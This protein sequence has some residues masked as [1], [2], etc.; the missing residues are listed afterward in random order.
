MPSDPIDPAVRRFAVRCLAGG[1]LLML[2]GVVLGAFGTH[3]LQEILTPKR[4]ASFQT[5]VTYQFLHALGLILI[6]VVARVTQPS[7]WLKRAA[8]LMLLGVV[9]FA[10][11]IYAMTFGAPR[12]LGMVAPVGGVSFM[13][14]WA[15]LALHAR[16]QTSQGSGGRG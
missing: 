6:G 8:V 4:L 5:G 15:A 12:W 16:Q 7:P 1:A 11:S 10:G 3:V 14:G 13:L 2:I 9:F